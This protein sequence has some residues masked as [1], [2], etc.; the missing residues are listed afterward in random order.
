M[1]IKVAILGTRGIPNQ[2]GGFEQFAMYFA[3]F[4][5]EQNI[6]VT[7]YSS[8]NHPYQKLKWKNVTI[9][10]ILDPEK[11]IGSVGQF[12]YDFLSIKHTRKEHFDIIFQLGYTSSSVWSWY[13]PKKSVIITNMDGLEWKR[14]KY[15]KK[16]QYFLKLAEKWAVK[17]SHQLIADSIGIQTYL[18]DK[19]QV[20]STFIPY[21]AEEFTN[22][23]QSVLE[24][25]NLQPKKYCLLIARM[26]PENNI[27]MIIRGFEK[28]DKETLIIVGNTNTQHGKY[29]IEK[30]SK[31]IIF[32]QGIYNQNHLNNLRYYSKIYFHGHSVGGTNPSLL[33]AM[34][35]SSF[36]CA[37]NN[38]F[39][40][41]VLG[42]DTYYFS[43]SDEVNEILKN[44]NLNNGSFIENNRQK[45]R[46]IYNFKTVHQQLLQLI[47]SCIKR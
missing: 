2:Y 42:A 3:E 43:S 13:F 30:Y 37:H 8:S 9:K 14:S 38:A 23:D 28:Q 19:Y 25:Y 27:E 31:N 34:A 20:D 18:K 22:P 29:L 4:L 5:S 6:D 7:V 10:H 36:V 47:N 45:I 39:N 17:Y 16:V 46:T 11:K 21:G 12:I 41:A 26:E 1:R 40:R 33:E 32:L 24:N 35:C 44:I 15:N